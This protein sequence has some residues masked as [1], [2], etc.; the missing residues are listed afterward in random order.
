MS[1]RNLTVPRLQTCP[2]YVSLLNWPRKKCVLSASRLIRLPVSLIPPLPTPPLL[3]PC[4]VSMKL[5]SEYWASTFFAD[6]E[7]INILMSLPQIMPLFPEGWYSLFYLFT[8]KCYECIH[9]IVRNS[10]LGTMTR[11]CSPVTH[12]LV[13]QLCSPHSTEIAFVMSPVTS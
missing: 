5:S 4:S 6:N 12:P 1:V 2:I 3:G 8:L 10:L 13:P 11:R 9:S 7:S